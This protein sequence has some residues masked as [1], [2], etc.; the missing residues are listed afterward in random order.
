LATKG[1]AGRKVLCLL[2]LLW[3][4]PLLQAQGKYSLNQVFSNLDAVSKTFRSVQADVERTHV[5]VLVND[6]DVSSGKFYYVRQGKEPRVKLELTKPMQQ[7]LLIDKGKMQIYTPNLKQVQQG[8]LGEHQDK[9]DMFMA[10]GFGQSSED[11]KKN[12][13]VS[14]AGEEVVDGKNTTVL[15]LLPKNKA[16]FRS[17]RMWIDPVRWIA[18]QLKA[19]E[20]GNDYMTFKYSNIK[21]NSK[22]SDTTFDLKIPKDVH[23]MKL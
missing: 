12:F 4:T 7:F 22:V 1:T 13:D 16:M 21:M 20:I 8:S 5:T 18:I 15:Q 3:L 6:K 19:T 11:L 23:V 9:V 17:V 10:L 14:L 2:C